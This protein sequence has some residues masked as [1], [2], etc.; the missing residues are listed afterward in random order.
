MASAN[1]G[2][3]TTTTTYYNDG[4]KKTVTQAGGSG[5]T[6]I[7]R[8][9]TYQYDA[10]GNQTSVQ[11]ARGF[12]TTTG[13]NADDE[14]SLVTDPDGHAALT[15][16]DGD[17]HVAQTVPPAGVAAGGLT[18][19]SCPVSYPSGYSDRLAPD[20]DMHAFDADGNETELSTPAP[21][22]QS[23]YETTTYAYDGDGNVLR[24]SAPPAANGGPN[25]VTVSMY[26]SADKLASQTTGYGTSAASTTTFCYDPEGDQTAVVAPDGNTSGAAPC[27][28]SSPWAV[29]SGSSPAQAAYQTTYAY[30]SVGEL[31]SATTPA[32]TAAPGGATTTSTY[33]PAGNMLTSTDPKQGVTTWTYTPGNVRATA[34]YSGSLA[35]AVTYTYDADGNRISM[36]DA[37]GNSAYAYD[38]F[39]DL[40]SQTN[41]ASQAISYGYNPDGQVTSIAYP[42]PAAS[43]WA[44]GNA[45]TYSYDN[46]GKLASVTDFNGN[47]I[48]ITDT[49]DGFPKTE[50]LGSTGDTITTNYDNTDS[51]SSI[52]L[53]NATSTLQSFAYSDGP[54]LD[55]LTETDTPSSPQSPVTYGYDSQGRLT[56]MA[57][58]A[59]TASNYAF[60]ASGNLTA[61]PGGGAATY[62]HAGEL[63]S[64][65]VS[66]T[67]ASYSYNA[68]GERLGVTLSGNAVASAAWNGAAQL[69]D[70]AS[71]GASM[72]GATYDGDG[73]RAAA[74]IT[75][76]GGS[77]E[78]G[79]FTWETAGASPRLLMD[80]SNAYIYAV[81]GTPAEQV[82][83]STGAITYPVSDLLGSVRG[84]VNGDGS[85]AA[86]TSYDAWG[87]PQAAGGLSGYTPFGYAG[88]Y[89]DSTGLIYLLKRYY[90]PATG[91]FI[92]IDPD[93]KET[94][95]PYSYAAANPVSNIDPTG[96][97]PIPIG[98]G[99][100]NLKVREFGEACHDNR[101]WC[102]WAF[103]FGAGNTEDNVVTAFD[104]GYIYLDVSPGP[105][106][107]SIKVKPRGKVMI[108]DSVVR[109]MSIDT[110]VVC[111]QDLSRICGSNLSF[112]QKWEPFTISFRNET[113]LSGRRFLYLFQLDTELAKTGAVDTLQART[114]VGRCER[115]GYTCTF[116][117]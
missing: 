90:D 59:G 9:T 29:S 4:R 20:D 79:Q 80:S 25:Q 87:N 5:A 52:S 92:S 30:D 35:H 7:P 49:A 13:Y 110:E 102:G 39:G 18:P 3:Y 45:V 36:S 66:G 108:P 84:I 96:S 54:S 105:S 11:D 26:N 1:V 61:I 106:G 64:S 57:P 112:F 60:D 47:Q 72:T 100:L 117:P 51:P 65:S 32:T 83:L 44:A 93:V 58:S 70:Y 109:D 27:G 55:V 62:D 78:V 46:A 43:T 2:N 73:L 68:D 17:G 19:G 38:P 16:Y 97:N 88:G 107:S 74:T 98:D 56:S 24:A 104:W 77:A 114:G 86:T 91:Q 41:G 75:S 10:D 6:L 95:E 31:V 113:R 94:Q 89:T 23:G 42:L 34:S 99:G 21:A 28:M 14:P 40:T 22:G 15:C 12:T 8:T 82:D 111:G 81:S 101:T 50:N 116:N 67:T 85:V 37:T 53:G 69:T 115:T 71:G 48:G 63:S 33:D 76:S 103:A